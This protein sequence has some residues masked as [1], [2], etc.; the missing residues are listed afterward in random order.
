MPG[1]ATEREKMLEAML[2]ASGESVPVAKLAEAIGCD[3]PLARNLLT[4]MADTYAKENA[5]IQ[6]S[7]IDDSYRLCTNPVYYPAIQRLMQAKPRKPL[8][9]AML[10]ILAIIAFKQPVTRGV[11]ESIRGVNCDRG[12]N[13]LLQHGLIVEQGRLTDA[14]GRPILFG[15]SEE[16]LLFYGLSCVEELI[17]RV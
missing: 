17:D 14:P 7:V 4:R 12:V 8:S 5:G 9:Q 16:F 11:I 15:T 3:I 6:L 1:L 2:F 10:E 13:K